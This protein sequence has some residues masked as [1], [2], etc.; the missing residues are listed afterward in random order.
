VPLPT[1]RDGDAHLSRA[2][3]RG[4]D[5]ALAVRGS[6]DRHRLLRG[7]QPEDRVIVATTDGEVHEA[8]RI[9]GDGIRGLSWGSPARELDELARHDVNRREANAASGAVATIVMSTPT[10]VAMS[11]RGGL[12]VDDV[13]SM[14]RWRVG[15]RQDRTE[16][17]VTEWDLPDLHAIERGL[18]MRP[19]NDS[20]RA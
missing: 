14:P 5:G 1:D 16:K 8:D 6:E 19:P 13:E 15:R 20:L 12:I 3:E 7:L 11:W 2:H 17:F 10:A 18:S 4:R 9:L